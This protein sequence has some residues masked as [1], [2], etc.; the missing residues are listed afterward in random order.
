MAYRTLGDMRAELIRRLGYGAAGASAGVISATVDSFL[1]NAHVQIYWATDWKR[2][3]KYAD[4][5]L[6]VDQYLLDYPEDA[7]PE[8]IKAIWVN[9]SGVWQEVKKGISEQ[10]YTYQDNNSW[11]ARYEEYAQIEVLPKSD[12]VYTVRIWYI[13]DLTRFSQDGDRS[14][15]DDD[16]VFLHALANAKLHYKQPDGQVYQGQLES[17]LAKL[18]KNSWT[19]RV[20]PSNN[21][22]N[23]A[24][25]SKPVVV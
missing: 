16:L 9:V 19:Q 6:G 7:N 8:R 2:L 11:P 18:K 1:Y 21:S 15:V 24:P 10:D 20:F 22:E 17:L 25:L 4:K 12:A 3:R 23:L 13:Q 5:T 14:L